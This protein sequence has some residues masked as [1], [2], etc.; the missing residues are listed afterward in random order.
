MFLL[1][2]NSPDLPPPYLSTFGRRPIPQ[3]VP[4]SPHQHLYGNLMNPGDNPDID[5]HHFD[6]GSH[7]MP[8]HL[9]DNLPY[10]PDYN[11]YSNRSGPD[12]GSYNSQGTPASAY[13]VRDPYLTD[14]IPRSHER[15]PVRPYDSAGRGSL[16]SHDPSRTGNDPEK[17][18]RDNNDHLSE[19]SLSSSSQVSGKHKRRRKKQTGSWKDQATNTDASSNGN[20]TNNVCST[21]FTCYSKEKES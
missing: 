12:Y 13:R 3:S 11:S 1:P 9:Q 20:V 21:R 10:T 5:P 6:N 16:G 17:G 2:A 19:H 7:G 18:L 4:I 14:H 8:H 15:F